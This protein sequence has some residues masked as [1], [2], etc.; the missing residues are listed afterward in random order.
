MNEMRHKQPREFWKMF[1]RKQNEHES[2]IP[3]SDFHTHFEQL[4][5]E[6]Q[7]NVDVDT[8]EFMRNFDNQTNEITFS[9]LDGHITQLEIRN[10]AKKLN[11]NK[12]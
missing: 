12:A 8:E 3:L 7:L 9:E 1:K 6:M 5:T 10:A 4:A 11:M 2:S